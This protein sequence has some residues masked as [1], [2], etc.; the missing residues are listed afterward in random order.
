MKLFSCPL[1]EQ[2]NLGQKGMWVLDCF[3]KEDV[4]TCYWI[5]NF[6]PFNLSK[7]DSQSIFSSFM[8]Q[9]EADTWKQLIL[10]TNLEL[11]ISVFCNAFQVLNSSK[12]EISSGESSLKYKREFW[13]A[14][15]SS[16]NM[17]C[18]FSVRNAFKYVFHHAHDALPQQY[19]LKV[20]SDFVCQVADTW[21]P[22]SCSLDECL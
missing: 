1:K 9:A 18:C 22:F 4:V 15:S 17:M 6:T 14:L 5:D 10:T 3:W 2:G 13:L 12:P 7:L 21:T 11:F 19:I 16:D 8:S 20:G